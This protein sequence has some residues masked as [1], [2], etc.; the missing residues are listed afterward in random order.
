MLTAIIKEFPDY[1][2]QIGTKLA[3]EFQ[4][5]IGNHFIDLTYSQILVIRTPDLHPSDGSDN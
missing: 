1:E 3:Q 5:T 2:K 4:Q